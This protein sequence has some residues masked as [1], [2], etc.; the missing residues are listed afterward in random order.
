V[1]LLVTPVLI[2][3]GM[4]TILHF[5]VRH[6]A[7]VEAC[8]H[9]AGYETRLQTYWDIWAE[10]ILVPSGFPLLVWPAIAF[11]PFAIAALFIRS[12][13][14]LYCQWGGLGILLPILWLLFIEETQQDPN[15]CFQ[16]DM[17][18][19]GLGVGLT[20]FGVLFGLCLPVFV[21]VTVIGI[22]V[23]GDEKP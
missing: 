13:S 20:T 15:W 16:P 22:S 23:P 3:I 7:A 11:L 14:R 1:R 10:E 17:G 9:A 21:L 5:C 6:D 19:L 8:S 18:D 2:L 4:A 12:P